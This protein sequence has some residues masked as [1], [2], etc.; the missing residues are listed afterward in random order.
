MIKN[1]VRCGKEF[2]TTNNKQK[3]CSPKCCAIYH[4]K[5][6]RKDTSLEHVA[7][8]NEI[9]IRR[10]NGEILCMWCG[11]EFDGKQNQRFCCDEH[12]TLFYEKLFDLGG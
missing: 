12:A 2:E 7:F 11:E 3:Y 6:K 9:A 1:C 5:K 4:R 8:K 10:L